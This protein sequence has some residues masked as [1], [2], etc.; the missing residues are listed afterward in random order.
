MIN[1]LLFLILAIN[2]ISLFFIIRLYQASQSGRENQKEDDKL[3]QEVKAFVLEEKRASTSL[4][5]RRFRVGYARAARFLDMLEEEGIIGPSG[6][7][8]NR[9]VLKK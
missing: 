1:L 4:I 6:N 5:Q 8:N 2:I 3:Y 7:S 9:E